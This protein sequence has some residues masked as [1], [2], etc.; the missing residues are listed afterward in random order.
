MSSLDALLDLERRFTAPGAPENA[1]TAEECSRRL[2]DAGLW[3]DACA[4]TA[5][6]HPELLHA[7]V[8]DG[9][10]ALDAIDDA[11][12]LDLAEPGVDG[13]GRA[14]T[15][16]WHVARMAWLA[17]RTRPPG[18]EEADTLLAAAVRRWR[19]S[20]LLPGHG[21]SGLP[22]RAAARHPHLMSRLDELGGGPARS[23]VA[24]EIWSPA[25]RS[26]LRSR[27]EH[28]IRVLFDDGDTGLLG[29]LRLGVLR[30][31]PPGL[32]PDPRTMFDFQADAAF[33][34]AIT[35]SWKRQSGGG[36]DMPCVLWRLSID[37]VRLRRVSGSSLGAAFA[38]LLEETLGPPARTSFAVP[39]VPA[40][41]RV[42]WALAR[43]LRTPR[44]RQAVTGRIEPTGRLGRVGGLAAKLTR[45]SQS[46]MSVVAPKANEDSD[47]HLADGVRIS[48]AD[49]V[50]AARRHLYRLAPQRVG[51][52]AGLA[53]LVPLAVLGLVVWR[54]DTSEQ[55]RTALSRR[56]AEAGSQVSAT[57]PQLAALLTVAAG[58]AAPT[59]EARQSML[60]VL[61]SP[62]RAVLDGHIQAS[63]HSVALS[64]SGRTVVTGS[65]DARPMWW[66]VP[67]RAPAEP[68]NNDFFSGRS[69]VKVVFSPDGRYVAATHNHGGA[70][71]WDGRTHKPLHEF[72]QGSS[73]TAIA[74]MPDSERVLFADFSGRLSLWDIA[75]RRAV[76]AG[77]PRLVGSGFLK[78]DELVLSPD[79]TTLA[80]VSSDVRGE[81]SV[82][83]WDVPTRSR[84][85]PAT[86]VDDV[87]PAFSADG[88]TLAVADAEGRL[89][90][91]DAGRGTRRTTLPAARVTALGFD[92]R[93][94]LWIAGDEEGVV[95]LW[96]PELKEAVGMA[97]TGHDGAVR[98]IDVDRAG[99]TLVSGGEDGRTRLWDLSYSHPLQGPLTAGDDEVTLLA[100]SPDA[101]TLWTDAG[102]S[103]RRNGG[104]WTSRRD[105]EPVRA[106]SGDGRIWASQR[107]GGLTAAGIVGPGPITLH[108]ASGGKPLHTIARVDGRV[109]ELRALNR[110]GTRVAVTLERDTFGASTVSVVDAATGKTAGK[111]VETP[112]GIRHLAFGSDGNSSM[113]M[114]YRPV[115]ESLDERVD[116]WDL[117]GPRFL[118]R[119]EGDAGVI[120]A[121]AF[122]GDGTRIAAATS[123]GS[124]R[125][126]N[127]ATGRPSGSPVPTGQGIVSLLAFAPDGRTLMSSG[128]RG[129]WRAA[130]HR[131]MRRW[132]IASGRAVGP[133]IEGGFKAVAFTPDGARM[134]TGGR[135]GRVWLW[136]VSVPAELDEALCAMA[137]TR[138]ITP[139]EWLTHAHQT[140]AP[141]TC[142]P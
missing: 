44:T 39:A 121:L 60:S 134:A 9:C 15:G 7:W 24:L 59:A 64:P 6:T 47:G 104:G 32:F 120:D 105:T 63:L 69:V 83:L 139:Q 76:D 79:G 88:S 4:E 97:L 25:A 43:P 20:G 3:W 122:S 81:A 12:T 82:Q 111:P 101:A 129:A 95:R 28:L 48:W 126:W 56:L 130:D 142:T 102:S 89:V 31:G 71:L 33:Q 66:D 92:A 85:G 100:F 67:S 35:T 14:A 19:D 38:V 57:D 116:L 2:I 128:G 72:G 17:S 21:L 98:A 52:L 96:D 41:P 1:V 140:T 77:F 29:T 90:L 58:K 115:P 40:V 123:D 73:T 133:P 13:W 37:D 68:A 119:L 34:D 5:R 99:T 93:L 107:Q 62:A 91:L 55:L 138:R 106:V 49:D 113:A 86:R 10:W 36:R 108:S 50:A 51:V 103:F 112:L 23:M 132:D 27:R 114:S 94:N 54:D 46:E 118:R 26:R 110:D 11:D 61:A 80:A 45:A 84:R 124:V 70:S 75:G 53:L 42:R 78:Y 125:L 87:R 74:F 141:N 30:G 117:T 18:T 109:P 135:K 131:T 22:S 136:N 127:A 65:D 16:A 137:G 8:R